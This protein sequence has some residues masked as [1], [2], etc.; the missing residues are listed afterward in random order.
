MK[1]TA[2]LR[3]WAGSAGGGRAAVRRVEGAGHQVMMDDPAGLLLALAYVLPLAVA[4]T[5]RSRAVM[6]ALCVP[7][8]SV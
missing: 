8:T 6:V 3:G 5:V 7:P 4:L 2:R 1:V